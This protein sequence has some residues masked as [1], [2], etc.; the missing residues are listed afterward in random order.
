MTDEFGP[1]LNYLKSLYDSSHQ[2]NL[3]FSR[4]GYSL[5]EPTKKSKCQLFLADFHRNDSRN[6]KK[7]S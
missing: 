3:W 2:E 6:A 5:E 7:P 1:K 4:S